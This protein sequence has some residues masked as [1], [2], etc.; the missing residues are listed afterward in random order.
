M[1]CKASLITVALALV[2]SAS[3]IIKEEGVRIELPKRASLTTAD[4]VFDHD[5]AIISTV[6]TI[7][8]VYS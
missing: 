8:Y 5:A 4:G 1:F 2:A 7:K 6:R 3:P